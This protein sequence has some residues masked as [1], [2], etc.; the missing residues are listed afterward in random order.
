M[1]GVSI[2]VAPCVRSLTTGLCLAPSRRRNG[3][4][5][6]RNSRGAELSAFEASA[7]SSQVRHSLGCQITDVSRRK[8]PLKGV[9]SSTRRRSQPTG[10]SRKGHVQ[11]SG[12][13]GSSR[14]SL[15][16]AFPSQL[17]AQRKRVIHQ[18]YGPLFP[19]ESFVD[20]CLLSSA[21]S[22]PLS[23]RRALD[24]R[25]TAGAYWSRGE[26]SMSKSFSDSA[27]KF[28]LEEYMVTVDRPLGIRFALTD[29]GVVIA[30]SLMKH[31]WGH[32][33]SIP[34]ITVPLPIFPLFL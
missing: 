34:L 19:S 33:P 4:G 18:S 22:G 15:Y 12:A 30:E 29:E 1:A 7:G 3:R 24:D 6:A 32:H 26:G 20:K 2:H 9:E 28:N 11:A 16:E 13:L 25:L 17:S 27:Y 5:K 23:S 8:R 14:E 10:S 31:V 21:M